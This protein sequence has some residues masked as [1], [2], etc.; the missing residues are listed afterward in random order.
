M[1]QKIL[2]DKTLEA[3][4]IITIIRRRFVDQDLDESNNKLESDF[5]HI[6]PKD[7][8]LILQHDRLI[9]L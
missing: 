9:L 8:Q 3:G 4:M 1:H 6:L 2:N 7:F 5:L